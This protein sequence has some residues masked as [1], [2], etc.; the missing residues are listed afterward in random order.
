MPDFGTQALI[1]ASVLNALVATAH[2]V[3]I[4]LGAPAYRRMGAS[5]GMIAAVQAGKLRP[6]LVTL[7]IAAVLFVWAAYALA[8]AG[9]IGRLPLTRL[10]LVVICA[11]YLTRALAF[12]LLKPAFP[13]NS[14]TFWLVSSGICLVLGMVHLLGIVAQWNSL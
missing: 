1:T 5:E 9:V 6:T 10:A 7:A 4:A 3:C 11:V 12:P 8:G 13:A 2:L 14:Q